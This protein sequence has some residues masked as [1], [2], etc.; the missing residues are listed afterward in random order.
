MLPW[1]L[2]I[3]SVF[4]LSVCWSHM[5]IPV[6]EKAGNLRENLTAAEEAEAEEEKQKLQFEMEGETDRMTIC[7]TTKK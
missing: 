5:C 4:F 6:A 3:F 7:V 1:Q 2:K